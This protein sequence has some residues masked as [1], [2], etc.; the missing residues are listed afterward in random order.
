MTGAI[1]S[2]VA[3]TLTAMAGVWRDHVEVFALD[4]QP[5]PADEASGTPGPSPWENLVYVEFDGEIYR[6]TNV[7]TRGRPLHVRS[8]TGRLQGGVLAFDAL[9]PDDP[10]HVG[11]SAGAGILYFVG[12]RITPAWSR[13]AEPDCVRLIDRSARV[14]STALYRDGV[15]VRT[16]TAHGVRVADKADRRVAWDPRGADGPVHAPRVATEVFRS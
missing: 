15:L 11:V 4:G 9:G 12:R 5:L 8:F 6:Q 16:L 3:E 14:R 10:E 7:T 13:Y 2:S 1:G